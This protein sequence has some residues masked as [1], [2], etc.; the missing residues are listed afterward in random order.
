MTIRTRITRA[1]LRPII[2]GKTMARSER[3]LAA[4]AAMAVG[5]VLTLA[6]TP[7]SASVSQGTGPVT[8]DRGLA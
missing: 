4:A 1:T 8:K 7:A 6:P 2:T 5:G 3:G